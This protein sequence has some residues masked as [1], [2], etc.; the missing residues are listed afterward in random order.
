MTTDLTLS[1]L[2]D[3]SGKKILHV[4]TDFLK[5]LPTNLKQEAQLKN[6]RISFVSNLAY[7]EDIPL[8]YV[9]YKFSLNNCSKELQQCVND[10]VF[11]VKEY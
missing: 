10:F 8:T 3:P 6:F 7:P 5:N 9:P 1:E 11:W 2:Q 4:W